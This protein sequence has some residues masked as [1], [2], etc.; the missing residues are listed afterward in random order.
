MR[1]TNTYGLPQ[2]VVDAMSTEVAPEV[3]RQGADISVT[4]L[5]GPP[6]M[7]QLKEKNHDRIV[8]DASEMIWSVLGR[9]LHS[10][11]D[12]AARGP[13]G[14]RLFIQR[15]GNN[16]M[17]VIS[18]EF[19]LVEGATLWDF[20]EVKAAAVRQD[21]TE[22]NWQLNIYR[23]MCIENGIPVN[24]L[25][26]LMFIRDYS[27]VERYRD[28][29]YP[30][31]PAFERKCPVYSKETV[32]AY[33]NY[34]LCEHEKEM[35]MCEPEERWA[36]PDQYAVY[37][38]PALGKAFRVKDKLKDAEFV[39]DT[40][41]KNGRDPR[42]IVIRHRPGEDLRCKYYC[43]VAEYCDHGRKVRMLDDP[44]AEVPD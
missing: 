1:V 33:I 2:A 41:V 43:S 11:I 38:A 27:P 8:V 37:V 14:V 40:M 39:R 24:Y 19:D 10:V 35:P 22:W 16:R 15:Q 36:K 4:E 42:S 28:P 30:M 26:N 23:L 31:A 20:K 29:E 3:R 7:K 21:K 25:K 44:E 12:K 34:Q 32:E 18:G 5:I 13:S 6:R 17:W 9:R